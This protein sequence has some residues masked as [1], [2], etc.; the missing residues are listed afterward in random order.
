MNKASLSTQTA[1]LF[2]VI[3]KNKVIDINKIKS[4]C[5]LY[6]EEYAF[7]THKN[8]IDPL[9]GLCIPIHYHIVMNAKDKRKRLSTHLEDI[10]SFFG[11]KNNDGIEI[12]KYRSFENALQYLIHKNDKDKTQHSIDEIITNIDKDELTTFITCDTLVI[13]FDYIYS[14]CKNANNILDVIK[15]L[16]LSNYQRYRSTIWDIWNAIKIDS[17]INENNNLLK[18]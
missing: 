2:I 17:L 14:L 8:D 9:T 12:D 13:S 15:A 10:R 18:K 16:G 11:F 7:I 6:G 5:E 3:R 1:R 4:Y